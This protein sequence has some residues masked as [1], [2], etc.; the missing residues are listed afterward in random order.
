MLLL[1]WAFRPRLKRGVVGE[2]NLIQQETQ[3]PC[4]GGRILR[5]V[6]PKKV[7]KPN[8]VYIPHTIMTATTR[9]CSP[10]PACS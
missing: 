2:D 1:T 9:T 4:T 10:I 5:T 7:L 3:E 6:T 8:Q